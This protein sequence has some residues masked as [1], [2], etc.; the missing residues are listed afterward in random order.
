M[1]KKW[2]IT[3]LSLVCLLACAIC[4]IACRDNGDNNNNYGWHKHSAQTYFV[5]ESLHWKVCEDCGEVF[6]K[7]EHNL[8]ASDI[9]QTCGLLTIYAQGL[10]LRNIIDNEIVIAYYI[11]GIGTATDT[12]IIIPSYYRGKPVTSIS[13]SAFDG[14]S[15]LTSITIPSS[16]TSIE[17]SAFSGCDKLIQTENGVQYVDKWVISC[18]TSVSSVNLRSNTAGIGDFAFCNCS[19]LLN[20]HT[21]TQKCDK[22]WIFV[23]RRLQ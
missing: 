9:C 13:H 20:K 3:I 1:K 7:G 19:S 4:L 16:I 5:D 23:I 2:L 10:E 22:Y 6:A 21:D 14:C 17:S 11:T 8:N 15:S 18:D 12:D